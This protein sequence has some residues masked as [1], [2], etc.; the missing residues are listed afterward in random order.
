LGEG[1]VKN[2]GEKMNPVGH[3]QDK[4]AGISNGEKPVR[5]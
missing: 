2:K 5:G 4:E 1:F 3:S